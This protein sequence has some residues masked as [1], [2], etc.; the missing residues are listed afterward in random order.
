MAQTKRKRRPTKHR[1]NPAGMVESR[2]RPGSKPVDGK[3]R[4]ASRASSSGRREPALA[5][6]GR[7]PSWRNAM[8]RAAI[9]TGIFFVVILLLFRQPAGGAIALAS[10]MFLVYVPMGYYTDLFLYRRWQRKQLEA[11]AAKQGS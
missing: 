10:F 3:P 9:A 7:P 4:Q 6:E 2:G 8:N 11:K 5:R 1:G